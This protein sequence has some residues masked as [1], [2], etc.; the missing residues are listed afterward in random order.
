[1]KCKRP[2][3]GVR[4]YV[5]AIS[6][7][8]HLVYP[9]I[10][11]ADKIVILILFSATALKEM[12]LLQFNDFLFTRKMCSAYGKQWHF[13]RSSVLWAKPHPASRPMAAAQAGQL[14]ACFSKVECWMPHQHYSCKTDG[15]ADTTEVQFHNCSVKANL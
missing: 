15:S 7:W 8:L 4:R 6:L 2:F 14:P 1:M 5:Y 13:D 12:K 11:N 3:S 9:S 10:F